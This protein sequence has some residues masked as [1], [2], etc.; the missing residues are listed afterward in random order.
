MTGF[1]SGSSLGTVRYMAIGNLLT[2]LK[3][4]FSLLLLFT[5]VSG[6]SETPV[7]APTG[8]ESAFHEKESILRT[9]AEDKKFDEFRKACATYYE[10]KNRISEFEMK[11]A[12][13]EASAEDIAQWNA[14]VAITKSERVEL[15]QFIRQSSLSKDDRQVMVWILNTPPKDLRTR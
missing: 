15:E 12:N 7:S 10:Q 2:P 13:K 14:L 3:F 6:C 4:F 5:V 8:D 11:M 1:Q 9:A